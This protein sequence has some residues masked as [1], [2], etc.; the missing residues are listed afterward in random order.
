MNKVYF[1]GLLISYETGNVSPFFRHGKDGDNHIDAVEWAVC[2]E[3]I[4]IIECKK[5][6]GVSRKQA[7]SVFHEFEAEFKKTGYVREKTVAEEWWNSL[8]ESQGDIPKATSLLE[9]KI[10]NNGLPIFV[11]QT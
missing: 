7:A 9:D 1:Y 2:Q 4:N 3:D 11:K 10:G 6:E 8:V 5:L